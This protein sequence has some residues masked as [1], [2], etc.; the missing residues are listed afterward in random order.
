M[1]N[2][3]R[4]CQ[5]ML[6]CYIIFNL[7]DGEDRRSRAIRYYITKHMLSFCM[8]DMDKLGKLSARIGKVVTE[9]EY[10]CAEKLLLKGTKMILI[11]HF[12]TQ[13]IF[14]EKDGKLTD[15][16]HHIAKVTKRLVEFC[17]GLVEKDTDNEDLD[18]LIASAEKLA[19]KVY[20]R[21]YNLI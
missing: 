21:F 12:L 14:D 9:I 8:G 17:C 7:A 1:L 5:L 6:P 3:K 20:E 13:L 11:T 16:Y 4:I 19:K 2:D 18:K 15:A 10:F